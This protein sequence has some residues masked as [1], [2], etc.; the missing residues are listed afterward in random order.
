ME[1][2]STPEPKTFELKNIILRREMPLQEFL[3]KTISVL[4]EDSVVKEGHSRGDR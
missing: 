1:T 2:S 4:S 3:R